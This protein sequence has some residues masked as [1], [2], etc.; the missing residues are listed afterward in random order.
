MEQRSLPFDPEQ[1]APARDAFEHER[2]GGA[3]DEVGDDRVD[4]EPPPGD[5]DP[6][7]GPVGTNSL[8]IP[9]RFASA[10][11]SRATVIFPIAQSEPTVST[12]FEPWV[13]FSP[14]GTLR[15]GGG[16]RRSRSSTPCRPASSASSGS[17]EMNSCR[18]FSTSSPFEMQLFSS[19]PPRRESA[20]PGSRRRRAPVVGPKQSASLTVPTTGK[21]VHA[22]PPPA[23]SRGSRRPARA[24]SADTPRAVLP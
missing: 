24:G 15:P 11:S 8:A 21:P 22:S 5:R 3:G 12:T 13:R 4:R 10:S 2:L 16:L 6:R 1:L 9:R 20:R 19:V 23:P 14:V 18:P 17:S 7:S